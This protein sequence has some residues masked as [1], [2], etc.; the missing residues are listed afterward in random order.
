MN[1]I[2]FFATAVVIIDA[3]GIG[4]L[5]PVLPDI[6]AELQD[7]NPELLIQNDVANPIG[8]LA[9]IGMWLTAVYMGMQ[10]LFGP[11]I[12][13]LSD[14][15]GRR[16]VLLISMFAL[17][18]DYLILGFAGSV[19]I[20]FLGRILAGIAGA[21]YGTAY[22]AVADVS[23]PEDKARNFGFIGAGFGIGFILGPTLGAVL[24]DLDTRAPIFAAAI[25][26]FVNFGFGFFF[27]TE[28]LQSKS[29]RTFTWRRANPL[30]AFVQMRHVPQAHPWLRSAFIFSLA[31]TV[32]PAV[33][34]YYGRAVAG[35]T[36]RD[37]GVSLTV[38]GVGFALVQA[39][40]IGWLV[41]RFGQQ[42]VFLIGV[43]SSILAFLGLTF[44]QNGL[45][46]Y[47]FMPF[48]A[49]AVVVNPMIQSF[50]SNAVDDNQQGEIQGI[51]TSIGALSSVI[52]PFF[53]V[54]SF[55]LAMPADPEAFR[56][57]GAP[58]LICTVLMIVMLIVSKSGFVTS[59]S[60]TES[61]H[62][63]Q[64]TIGL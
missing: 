37:I 43:W 49:F 31:F 48:S 42:R 20:L 7:L 21:T 54:G 10:F 61:Q 58:F 53:M 17:G 23:K 11:T 6:L 30:G 16:L 47:L 27:F 62:S 18:I 50:L 24:V 56:F 14:R 25:L 19:W 52:S 1:H 35:W 3:M 41:K 55:A 60:K 12:G 40:L 51:S 57:P 64:R 28:T 46:I 29:R 8:E 59:R 63:K 44:A 22:A 39:F 38:I 45:Q 26:S 9:G 34:S 4:L 36:A 33:W 15:Y 5:M 2:I 13:N 32:Y